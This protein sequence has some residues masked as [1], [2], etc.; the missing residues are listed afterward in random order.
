[1]A[2]DSP[3]SKGAVNNH[4]GGSRLPASQ[5]RKE[6]RMNLREIAKKWLEDN[7]YDG[8]S[9]ENC[10]CELSDLMPCDEPQ[11][12]CE[13]G[14]KVPCPGPEL[15]PADGD[16]PWHISPKKPERIEIAKK[17]YWAGFIDNKI[18]E[19]IPNAS[20][21]EYSPCDG[22]VCVLYRLKRDARARF[23]DVRKVEIGEVS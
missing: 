14:Y 3:H 23:N 6:E 17:T 8:L 13:A 15:C 9:N 2:S 18:H 22:E 21:D 7:G 5:Y 1:M 11:D 4:Y 19:D 16:C 20:M 12:N 10:G